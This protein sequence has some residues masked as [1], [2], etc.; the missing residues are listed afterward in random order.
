MRRLLSKLSLH[1]KIILVLISVI[2]PTFLIVTFIESQSTLPILKEELRQ[3][4]VSLA[5]ILAARIENSRVL[6]V[7]H[8]TPALESMLQDLLFHQPDVI[9]A[10]VFVLESSK[11]FFKMVATNIAE[12]EAPASLSMS[13]FIQH[14]GSE[15]MKDAQGGG[16]YWEIILP[17]HHWSREHK[18]H[19]RLVGMVRLS[20]STHLAYQMTDVLLR[21]QS[22]AAGT[23]VV[24][25]VFALS[26]FL[27][28]TISNDR[29]LR[30]TANKNHHLIEQLHEIQRELMNS[31]K[32]AVMGQLTASFAHEIGTPLNAI[33]GHLQ[34]LSEEVKS[35]SGLERLDIIQGQV[36]KIEVI[37]QS[38]LQSTSKPRSQKQLIDLNHLIDR[39]LAVIHPRLELLQVKVIK[40]LSHSLGPVRVVPIEFEQVL[41]NLFNNSLDSIRKKGDGS[42]HCIEVRTGIQKI[43]AQECALISV[44]DTGEGIRKGDLKNVFKPFFSTKSPGEGTGLGLTICNDIIRKYGGE[45][46]IDSKEGAWTQVN[47]RLPYHV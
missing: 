38:F 17:I 4:G 14:Q 8:P 15:Y 6:T 42:E 25:L 41:L 16:G 5:E 27:R 13:E 35:H 28:K 40:S 30:L 43:Q 39:T 2:I 21:M 19:K 45:M 46:V 44:Y 18:A 12:D 36:H 10:E 26:Y 9:R 20:V 11:E 24:I 34:L 22:I 37:V 33:G 3:Q 32:L 1:A 7:P 23:S 47:I 29:L 31:E